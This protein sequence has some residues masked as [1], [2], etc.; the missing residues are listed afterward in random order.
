MRFPELAPQARADIDRARSE[1]AGL[2]EVGIAEGYCTCR[3]QGDHRAA[4]AIVDQALM[5]KIDALFEQ[6]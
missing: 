6:L 4:L 5:K 1:Q 3:V 2:Y